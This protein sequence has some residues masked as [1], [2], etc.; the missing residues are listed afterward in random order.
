MIKEILNHVKKRVFLKEGPE[1][2]SAYYTM[3]NGVLDIEKHSIV[4]LSVLVFFENTALQMH[5]NW[6]QSG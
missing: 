2:T 4:S 3:E 5:I 6:K 1:M